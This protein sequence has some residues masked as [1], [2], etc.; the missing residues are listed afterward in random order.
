MARLLLV[1]DDERVAGA[2]SDALRRHG[3]EV[4]RVAT[5]EDALAAPPVDLVLL[6]LGLPDIDGLEVCDRLRA[7]SDLPIIAV[8]ARGNP[9]ERVT[10]LRR[11]ADDYVVK[12]FS[13]AELT[14][15][16][17]AVLRR[18]GLPTERTST[19]ACGSLEVDPEA[20]SVTVGGAEVSLAPLEFDLLLDL[21]HHAGTVRSRQQLLAEVWRNPGATRSRTVDVHVG[22]LRQKLGVAD[23]IRTVHGVGYRLV[24]A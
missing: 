1:E 22:S 24:P 6:D 4:A 7:R 18:T 12:P 20:R 23:L 2:V 16:I 21:V 19:I 10:G 15:R 14:A 17:E 3:Y 9:V 5:G 8:T 13:I 11:G